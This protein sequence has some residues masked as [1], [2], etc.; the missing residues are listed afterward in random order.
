[1]FGKNRAGVEERT[2]TPFQEVYCKNRTQIPMPIQE[3]HFFTPRTVYHCH[4]GSAR[5]LLA[6]SAVVAK[7]GAGPSQVYPAAMFFVFGVYFHFDKSL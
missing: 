7:D 5:P 6:Y 1:M 4:R 3:L 2:F